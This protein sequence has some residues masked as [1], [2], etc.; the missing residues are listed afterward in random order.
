MQKKTRANIKAHTPTQAVSKQ[1]LID[2]D[3][4]DLDV[5]LVDVESGDEQS[6]VNRSTAGLEKFMKKP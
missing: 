5:N 3:D 1:K 6:G 2:K 4:S